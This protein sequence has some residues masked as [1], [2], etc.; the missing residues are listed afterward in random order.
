ML[1]SVYW[2]QPL[3]RKLEAMHQLQ[4]LSESYSAILAGL[5]GSRG[6]VI[7]FK[8]ARDRVAQI[9][10]LQ[11]SSRALERKF[12]LLSPTAIRFDGGVLDCPDGDSFRQVCELCAQAYALVH[13]IRNKQ[14]ESGGEFFLDTSP[15]SLLGALCETYGYNKEWI[16]SHFSGQFIKGV[17]IRARQA[18]EEMAQ[19][20]IEGDAEP[21]F[22]TASPSRE[23][24]R[25]TIGLRREDGS[26]SLVEQEIV[27]C[28]QRAIV[29]AYRLSRSMW[30]EFQAG[31]ARNQETPAFLPSKIKID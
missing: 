4:S 18:L 22:V 28:R 26:L 29:D 8:L 17:H 25:I 20:C 31:Q 11:L 2:L 23:D 7:D 3:Q 21:F 13:R 5:S 15:M 27:D 16:L 12:T 14:E 24:H 9:A 19:D 1:E 6:G 10:R 30:L